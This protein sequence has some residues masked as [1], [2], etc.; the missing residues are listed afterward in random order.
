MA[1]RMRVRFAVQSTVLAVLLTLAVPSRAQAVDEIS[2]L[3]LKI[4]FKI[5][6]YDLNLPADA[7]AVRIG[8]LVPKAAIGSA[9]YRSLRGLFANYAS[10]RVKG[11]PF[12]V[13]EVAYEGPAEIPALVAE[14]KVYALFVTAPVAT[15]DIT[16]IVTTA[17]RERLLTFA[18]AP[19]L[20]VLGITAS[21]EVIEQRPRIVINEGAAK[22]AGR[23]LD[24]AL[25]GLA[26][27]IR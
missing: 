27:V 24:S 26:R 23:A 10:T 6:T 21:V 7:A 12:E 13:V 2:S 18:E 17:N 1:R 14:A 5:M 19:D 20:V 15:A 4:F 3:R 25:L 16:T 9:D 11:K 8:V 22:A